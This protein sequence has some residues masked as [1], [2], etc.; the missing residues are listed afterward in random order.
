MVQNDFAKVNTRLDKVDV[1]LDN[2]EI[3]LSGVE[4][5][6]REMKENTN[7]LFTKLDRFITLYETQR[8]ELSVLGVQLR[9]LE[10]RVIN[11]RD[12]IYLKSNTEPSYKNVLLI[13]DVTG[14]GA[15]FHETA[16]KLRNS[17]SKIGTKNI[18]AFAFVGN[19]KGYEVIREI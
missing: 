3:R 18:I 13:D 2:I 6:V 5:E 1:R 15:S 8:Q 14:S 4:K 17:K 11:A 7:E 10:E 9:R 16:K 12:T 19:I